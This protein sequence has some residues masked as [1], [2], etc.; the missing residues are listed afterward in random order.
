[1]T[2]NPVN[3]LCILL[4]AA[5]LPFVVL[6]V[7]SYTKLAVVFSLLRSALGIQQVP[8]NMVLYGISLVLTVYIMSPVGYA[9]FDLVKDESIDNAGIK[10]TIGMVA[11]AKD[12]LRSFLAKHVRERDRKFFAKTIKKLWPEREDEYRPD[13]MIVLIPAFMLSELTAAFEMGFVLY[14]PF[15]AIDLLVSNVLMALGMV[16]MSPLV[17]SLPFKLLLFVMLDGWGRIVHSLVL[18]YV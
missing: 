1:M 3:L 13:E 11:K 12:P 17:V 4:L 15:I 16:M 6:M 18:S 8:P 7:T 5:M 2:A 10:Q 9:V 14:M